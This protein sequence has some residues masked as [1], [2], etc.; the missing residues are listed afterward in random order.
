MSMT[1]ISSAKR[2]KGAGVGEDLQVV[3]RW[4]KGT[5]IPFFSAN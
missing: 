1:L 5:S 3:V 2:R 4:M